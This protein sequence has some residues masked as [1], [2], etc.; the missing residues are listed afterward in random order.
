[1]SVFFVVM[2]ERRLNRLREKWAYVSERRL[3]GLIFFL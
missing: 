2:S 1:M 3:N